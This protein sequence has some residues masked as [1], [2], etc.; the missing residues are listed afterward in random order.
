MFSKFLFDIVKDV[1]KDDSPTRSSSTY[2]GTGLGLT[3]LNDLSKIITG[4]EEKEINEMIERADE[5]ISNSRAKYEREERKT[6]RYLE[7]TNRMVKEEYNYKIQLLASIKEKYRPIVE[8]YA[9][10]KV[11]S[12]VYEPTRANNKSTYT[13]IPSVSMSSFSGGVAMIDIFSLINI[14]NRKKR[15]EK[16]K[17]YLE[18][19]RDFKAE[20]NRE[21]SK[22]GQI[23]VKAEYIRKVVDEEKYLL[24]SLIGKLDIMSRELSDV[25]KKSGISAQE[26]KSAN[27]AFDFSKYLMEL[28]SLR[29]ITEDGEIT[30]DYKMVLEK[31]EILEN[32]LRKV[33]I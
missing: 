19:A 33:G 4:S 11:Y 25:M 14:I 7:E 27:Y 17:E 28:L 18:E 12:E 16:A 9:E 26:K 13:S 5:I 29:F 23:V 10:F 30:R 8:K 2:M 6:K 31:I 1:V 21:I 3:P 20:V 15:K 22:L 32:D 24:S